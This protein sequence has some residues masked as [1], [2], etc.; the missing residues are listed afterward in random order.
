MSNEHFLSYGSGNY[1]EVTAW[2]NNLVGKDMAFITPYYFGVGLPA[3]GR[4]VK[5]LDW[6]IMERVDGL[7]IATVRVEVQAQ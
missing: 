1:R 2:L 4:V 5:I 6:Q 7:D 3:E